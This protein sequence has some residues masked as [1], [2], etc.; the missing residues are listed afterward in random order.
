LNGVN[1]V[2]R[3]AQDAIS[4]RIKATLVTVDDFIKR[5]TISPR[6]LPD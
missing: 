6:S 1:G 3:V 4:H 2:I 5:P